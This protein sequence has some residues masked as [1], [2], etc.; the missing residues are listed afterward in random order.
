MPFEKKNELLKFQNISLY[1]EI[2]IIII[3]I[4]RNIYYVQVLSSNI[5]YD[6]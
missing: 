3:T 2:I 5:K 4:L 6:T 1:N